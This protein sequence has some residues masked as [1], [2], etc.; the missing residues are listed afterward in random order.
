MTDF[1]C[2]PFEPGWYRNIITPQMSDHFFP[3]GE[4]RCRSACGKYHKHSIFFTKP[5]ER[6]D[7]R[8]SKCLKA[9]LGEIL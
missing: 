8:C 6:G 4:D 9:A 5:W 3:G 7:R 1:K 2:E